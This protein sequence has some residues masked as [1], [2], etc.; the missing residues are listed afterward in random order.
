MQRFLAWLQ[1]HA[2]ITDEQHNVCGAIFEYA[3][4]GMVMPPILKD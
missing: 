2:N 1:I 4:D 3:F